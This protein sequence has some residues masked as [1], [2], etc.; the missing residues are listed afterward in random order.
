MI[1]ALLCR[2]PKS[3]KEKFI[4]AAAACGGDKKTSRDMTS[5]AMCILSKI[6]HRLYKEFSRCDFNE[7]AARSVATIASIIVLSME[8]D[9]EAFG[10]VIDSEQAVLATTIIILTTIFKVNQVEA[11]KYYHSGKNAYKVILSNYG[12]SESVK[13]YFNDVHTMT[14]SYIETL[15]DQYLDSYQQLI[16]K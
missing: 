12:K 4:E 5:G 6:L 7:R 14:I 16:I 9:L 11:D 1:R 2:K 13:S 15:D 3:F 10:V 8:R